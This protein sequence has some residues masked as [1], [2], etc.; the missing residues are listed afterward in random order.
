ME[1]GD[2]KIEK[3]NVFEFLTTIF[4]IKIKDLDE[5]RWFRSYFAGKM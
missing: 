4:Y 5:V 3:L 1:F 2:S